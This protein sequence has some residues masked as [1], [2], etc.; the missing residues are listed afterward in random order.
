MYMPEGAT[1][2]EVEKFYILFTINECAS[3]QET[4]KV[5]EISL[6]TLSRKLKEYGYPVKG[7]WST[8]K[9]DKVKGEEDE[10]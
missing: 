8:G 3:L 2:K 7:H 6:P 9:W 1:L 10:A 5:L 4:A